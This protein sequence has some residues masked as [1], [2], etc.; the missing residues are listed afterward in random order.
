MYNFYTK[1]DGYMGFGIR[2]IW[3]I[4]SLWWWYKKGHIEFHFSVEELT[5]KLGKISKWLGDWHFKHY[6]FHKD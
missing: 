5:E 4:P 2:H 1:Q 3:F 6:K